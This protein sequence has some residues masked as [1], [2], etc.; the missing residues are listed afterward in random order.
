MSW[1]AV[2]IISLW[3]IELGLL[4]VVRLSRRSFPW[5]I[6]EQDELPTL[7]ENALQKFINYSF[8]PYLGW[9]R[10]PN[11]SGVEHGQK[12]EI[13]F[14]IDENGCRSN[15][16]NKLTPLIAAF[17]D[18]YVFCRQVEDNETWEAQ[19][20]KEKGFGVMNYGVGN[21]GA[22]QAL[23]RYEKVSLPETVRIVILGFVPESICRIQSYWK[24]Y[25]EFGNTFAFKPRFVFGSEGKLSLIENPIKNINDYASLEDILPRVQKL[26]KF[27]NTKFRSLQFRIPYALSFMR[28]PIRQIKLITAIGFRGILRYLGLNSTWSENL[29]FTLVMK[30]NIKEAHNFYSDKDST[31]LLKAIILR[32]KKA[33]SSRGHIPL[34]LLMPQLL[35]LKFAKDKSSPYQEFFRQMSLLLPV[36]DLT[37]SFANEEIDKLYINDQY[38][39]HL[40]PAGNLLVAMEITEWL[41]KT[42]LKL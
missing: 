12:G 42:D 37:N 6:T 38:G 21:Y 41:K 9:V 40:S 30:D 1:I 10:K 19:L 32:F 27:Y 5:L 16:F 29:P 34:V 14:Q 39:G 18:S 4:F 35:D 36:I 23:L 24:H 25:L 8:D 20:S 13:R 7:D 28:N 2:T 33:T 11:S 3:I 26:D 17:G 15:S 22:D 31:D